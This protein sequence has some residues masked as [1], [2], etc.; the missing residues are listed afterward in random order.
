M[1]HSKKQGTIETSVFGA[2]FVAMRTLMEVCRALRYKHRMMGI[3]IEE[4]N[5]CYPQHAKAGINVR[6]EIKFHMQPFLPGGRRP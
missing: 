3:P 4:P 5:Y 6:K 2:E 1:W